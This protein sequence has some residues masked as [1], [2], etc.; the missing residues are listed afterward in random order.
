MLADGLRSAPGALKESSRLFLKALSN[1]YIA[2][3]FISVVLVVGYLLFPALW[4]YIFTA[5]ISYFAATL[6]LR[7][8]LDRGLF[9]AKH[10][11]KSAISEGHTFMIFIFAII[12]ATIFSDWLA[13][14]IASLSILNPQSNR[15]LI[16]SIQTLVILGLIFLDLEFEL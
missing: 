14:Y 4:K 9:R 6:V 11:G 5:L 8:S 16:I 2:F 3:T 13:G 7:H 1:K 12:F 15:L 10:F